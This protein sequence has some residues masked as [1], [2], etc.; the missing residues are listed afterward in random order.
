MNTVE[1]MILYNPNTPKPFSL[2]IAIA[3]FAAALVTP[4]APSAVAAEAGKTPGQEEVLNNAAIIELHKMGL[5]EDVITAKIKIANC[6]F[7][8]SLEGLKSLKAAGVQDT[9]IKAMIE[10]KSGPIGVAPPSSAAGQRQTS[11][12][13]SGD[14][15]HDAAYKGDLDKVKELLK[16]NPNLVSSIRNGNINAGDTPLHSAARGGYKNVAELLLANKADVNAENEEGWTPLHLAAL[17]GHKDFAEL[18]LA[19]KANVNA[20]DKFGVQAMAL[21]VTANRKD[22]VELLLA[23]KAEVNAKDSNG[24]TA[25]HSAARNGRKEIAE[26]LLRSKA[27]VNAKS[28]KGDTPLRIAL[29]SGHEDLAEVLRQHGGKK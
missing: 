21:A 3:C 8:L 29:V 15:I 26:L 19:N 2:V 22:V 24:E 12:R 16:N 10:K 23:N 5:G 14:G 17:M 18:L 11:S 6:G 4:L 7:D 27:E 1:H 28:K 25:L 13:A 9:V 20:S